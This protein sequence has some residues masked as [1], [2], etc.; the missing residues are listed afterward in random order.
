MRVAVTGSGGLIGG[1]LVAALRADGHEATPVVR[2]PPAPGEI[3]W[4]P[5][6]G[7][8]DGEGLGACDAVVHLAGAGIGDHR[9]TRPHKRR[10]FDSRVDGTHLIA[11]TIA[12]M[13]PRPS[14]LLSASAGGWYGDR[15]DE[16]LTETSGP[17]TGFLADICRAWEEAA[18][19]AA[20]AGVRVVNLRSGIVLARR[21]GVV[22]VMARPFRFFVGGPVGTGRPW[23]SW[24]HLEDEIAAIMH[25]LSRDLR[26]PVNLAAPN[27]VRNAEFARALGRAL[28]RPSWFRAPAPLVELVAGRE[29]VR[30][31]LL[32][33]VRM[34]PQVLETSGFGFRHPEIGAAFASIFGSD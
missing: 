12:S 8:I 4:D 23:I 6:G 17:G 2:H 22:P 13:Q 25:L 26:G 18:R 7:T 34:A 1:A 10:I 14:V 28:H 27:P 21:G 20:A 15:G 31:A 9:W 29:R 16:V 32:S 5:A 24:I 19:P 33:S 11:R 30:E 3:R